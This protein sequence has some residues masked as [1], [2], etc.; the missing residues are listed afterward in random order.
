MNQQNQWLF[1]VPPTLQANES[2]FELSDSEWEVAVKPRSIRC[3]IRQP[4]QQT[5]TARSATARISNPVQ[6]VQTPS[7][8]ARSL[9]RPTDVN[10]PALGQPSQSLPAPGQ[11]LTYDNVR[12]DRIDVFAQKA[13]LRMSKNPA[14][15]ADAAGMAAAVKAGK[16]GGI[17]KEDQ[18][19]PALR[20]KKINPKAWWVHIIPKR[21][22]AVLFLDPDSPM[23]GVPIIVFR[24][25]VRSTPLRFDL[26]LQKAWQA[27]LLWRR[28]LIIPEGTTPST[29]NNFEPSKPTDITTCQQLV[30]GVIP[31]SSCAPVTPPCPPPCLGSPSP[32]ADL[33][34]VAIHEARCNL[35]LARD[36]LTALLNNNPGMDP[37]VRK[38]T[39]EAVE[40]RLKVTPS[41]P[42][43]KQTVQSAI[44]LVR[45][46]LVLQCSVRP[47]IR[48][49]QSYCVKTGYGAAHAVINE[50]S[51]PRGIALCDRWFKV[52]PECRR[53]VIIHEVF[54][55]T[56]KLHDME[57]T[58]KRGRETFTPEE[59]LQDANEMTQL[60]SHIVTGVTDTCYKWGCCLP[61]NQP[62]PKG[63][64]PDQCC[65]R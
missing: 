33:I 11:V 1:E 48:Q 42:K 26:A 63:Y 25:S 13:L 22:D 65:Q 9:P 28:G 17:Y 57:R 7:R 30:K 15:S 55:L 23:Q 12:S 49:D 45:E 36:A 27:C 21:E 50:D 10:S 58:L 43:F 39:L 35:G 38:R 60:V 41:H 32:N 46:N 34:D 6:R 3:P 18:K 14:M 5:Q 52:C 64:M 47:R 29:Q 59:S 8:A 20:I 31:R 61:C 53:E 51:K 62:I 4:I 44:D 40:D 16:L 37:N 19:V 56:W 54:H 24:D 2:S